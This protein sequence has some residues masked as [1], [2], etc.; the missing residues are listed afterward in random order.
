MKLENIVHRN[1]WACKN[2]QDHR[3]KFRDFT[4]KILFFK[5]ATKHVFFA[6]LSSYINGN[7]TV[8]KLSL[9]INLAFNNENFY[10]NFNCVYIG[11]GKDPYQRVEIYLN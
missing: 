9:I 5:I 7:V 1:K 2:I 8:K 3:S 6:R 4:T 11:S 10:K